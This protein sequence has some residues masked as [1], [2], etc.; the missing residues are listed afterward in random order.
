MVGLADE[1]DESRPRRRTDFGWVGVLL[2]L[3][4]QTAALFYWGGRMSATVDG[5]VEVQAD[6]EIRLRNVEVQQLRGR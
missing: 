2:A 4:I 6:H 3:L 5:V 1:D